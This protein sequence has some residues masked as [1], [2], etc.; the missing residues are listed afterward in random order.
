MVI[1][2][3]AFVVPVMLVA[4]V[5]MLLISALTLFG[6]NYIIAVTILTAKHALLFIKMSLSEPHIDCDNCPHFWE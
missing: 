2:L 3:L 5:T 6:Y 4:M 1:G